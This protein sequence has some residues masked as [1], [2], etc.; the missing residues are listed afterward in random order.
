M[1]YKL[2][3]KIHKLPEETWEGI[4]IGDV[5]KALNTKELDPRDSNSYSSE[6][7]SI[8]KSYLDSLS[9]LDGYLGFDREYVGDNELHIIKYFDTEENMK[10]Y[11]QFSISSDSQIYSTNIVKTTLYL[12]SYEFQDNQGNTIQI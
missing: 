4:H 8:F 11:H 7:K 10:L 5:S 2:I 12:I 6:E 9:K 1:P 3:K